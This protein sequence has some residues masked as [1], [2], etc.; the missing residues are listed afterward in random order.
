MALV[1]WMESLGKFAYFSLRVLVALPFTLIKPR[2]VLVQIYPMLVGALPLALT[3]GMAIGAVVSMHLRGSLIM[4]GGPSAVN[5]LP[6]AL[7][8]AVVL[9]FAPIAAGLLVAGRSGA[10]LGAELG[11]MRQTEQIDALE[12]LG[13]S[14]MQELIAP[15]VLACILALPVITIFIIYLALLSGYLVE[16]FAGGLSFIQYR[17]EVL[18]RLTLNNTISAVLKT[19][20]FGFWIGTAGCYWGTRATNGT[21]GVGKAATLGVVYSIFLVLVADVFLVRLIGL[22]LN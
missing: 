13:R 11:S 20:V 21:E 4:V 2:S 5:Y 16:A 15:R 9:E 6:Q 8:L 22:F 17:G 14:P 7:A 1:D 12:V 19:M 3:A 10:F 18:R